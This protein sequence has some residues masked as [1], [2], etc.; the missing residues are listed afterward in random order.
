MAVFILKRKSFGVMDGVANAGKS[1]AGTA[2]E[3]TGKLVNNGATRAVANVA[4][5]LGGASLMSSVGSAVG[6]ALLGPLGALG[7]TVV[8]GIAGFNNGGDV[9]KDAV[10]SI[11]NGIKDIGTDIKY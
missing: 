8:G 4:G 6:G 5:K 9:A 1:V 3:T 2:L 7:G 10:K 11:G